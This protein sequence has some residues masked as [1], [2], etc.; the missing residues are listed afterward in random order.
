MKLAAEIANKY[1]AE[2]IIRPPYLAT[3][4]ARTVDVCIH[5]LEE[6]VNLG[7]QYDIMCCLL[8]TA[9]LRNAE[10]I[11][12]T[13]AF[14]QNGYS[15]FAV[16]VSQY[17]FPPHQALKKTNSYLE[18]MWPDL[19]NKKS[20]EIPLLFVDNGSTYAVSVS[21]FLKEKSF[22][23][24]KLSGYLMPRTRSVDIDVKEDF[25]IALLFSENL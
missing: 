2:I 1:G 15:N 22:Y 16:A 9:P 3:D 18:P 23:G 19:I 12:Q 10:D 25:E 21:A 4:S 5:A 7:R 24:K 20:Q 8:A 11:K 13:V 17:H 6:E 14:V